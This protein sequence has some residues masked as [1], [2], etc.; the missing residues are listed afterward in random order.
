MP[1]FAYKAT[2]SYGNEIQGQVEAPDMPS[3]AEHVRVSGYI[4]TSLQIADPLSQDTTDYSQIT[5]DVPRTVTGVNL[6]RYDPD[7]PVVTLQPWER[8]GPVEQIGP[9]VVKPKALVA[10]EGIPSVYNGQQLGVVPRTSF[11][12]RQAPPKSL[13]ERFKGAFIY[14]L[15]SG[16]TLKDLV[17]YYNQFATLISA[18]LPLYQALV[19]LESQTNN[20]K[21]REATFAMMQHVQHGGKLSEAMSRYPTIFPEM[22]YAMISAGEQG[23]MLEQVLRQLSSYVE[24]ELSIKRLLRGETLYPKLVL[25]ACFLIIGSPPL[26]GQMPAVSL[27]VLGSLGKEPYTFAN[28]LHDTVGFAMVLLAPVLILYILFRLFLF[29]IKGV[30][31]AYDTVKTTIPALGTIVKGFA[32]ARF[33]RTFSALYKS[34]FTMSSALSIAG[35]SAGN[36]LLRN[37]AHNAVDH[38][39]HGGLVSDALAKSGMVPAMALNMMR[40]GES[41]GNMEDMLNKAADHYEEESKLKA[42]VAALVFSVAMLLL[43]GL[44]VGITVLNFYG[45]YAS[46]ITK[47]GG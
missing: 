41:S 28:Y 21:L 7:E 30:R 16:L 8:G 35:D 20:R 29:N 3:A 4:P 2:D 22:H 42:R 38:A 39:E 45:G 12:M 44:L 23:G 9:A 47:M 19:G 17:A 33:M 18:G 6:E 11:E 32:L 25:L 24:H 40:T 46:S 37:A 15:V 26:H 10:P 5:H 1:T 43:V 34:G 36:V 27:L 31:E 14:P 13:A